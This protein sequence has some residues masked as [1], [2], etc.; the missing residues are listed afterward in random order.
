MRMTPTV[1]DDGS[2]QLEM[3]PT[4]HQMDEAS[5]LK[6]GGVTIPGIRSGTVDTVLRLQP[7]EFVAIHGISGL[8]YHS[9]R[10]NVPFFSDLPLIGSSIYKTRR[11]ADRIERIILVYADWGDHQSSEKI[12][13]TR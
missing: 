6:K 4:M 12:A 2:L 9:K 3:K 5:G 1:L 13:T 8:R 11:I 7:G 10:E